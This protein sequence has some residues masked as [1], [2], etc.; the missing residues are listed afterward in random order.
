ML[1]AGLVCAVVAASGLLARLRPPGSSAAL[2]YTVFA[3]WLGGFAVAAAVLFGLAGGPAGWAGLG[4]AVAIV[5]A[6]VAVQA[7]LF[8]AS[9]PPATGPELVVLTSNLWVGRADA[10]AVVE[11]VGTH[12]VDVLLLQELTDEA[13]DALHV[14]GLDELLPHRASRPLPDGLGTGLWSRFPLL[15]AELRDDFGFALVIARLRVP[16][17][18][19]VTAVALHVYAPL[20]QRKFAGWADDLRRLPGLLDGLAGPVLAGGDFNAT[21]DVAQFRALLSSGYASAAAQA[22]AGITASYPADRRWGPVLAIDHVL[23]RGLVG[24]TAR[25]VA[26]RG[27]DHCALLTTLR[28]GGSAP[29]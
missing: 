17:A 7:P 6:H 10:G 1:I 14:A 25:T 11:L 22:G 5:G 21:P 13:Q 16:D 26:V 19:P 28:L 24:R 4:V 2:G 3:P 27:S 8:V 12:R 20:P 15:D 9:A 18:G 23:V 29:S